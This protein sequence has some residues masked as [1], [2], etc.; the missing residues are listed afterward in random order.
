[1]RIEHKATSFK[2]TISLPGDKSIS[3]RSLLHS[4]M[5]ESD[6]LVGNLPFSKDVD[7]T[8][9]ALWDLGAP[10]VGNSQHEYWV[11]SLGWQERRS[12]NLVNCH[13]SATTMRLLMGILAGCES[14]SMLTGDESLLK[15][16]MERVAEPLRMMG[17]EISTNNGYPPVVIKGR[18][19]L[20]PIRYKLPI[21]SAQ[22][23]SSLIYAAMLANGDSVI[24]EPVLSRDH[25]EIALETLCP[26]NYRR[27]TSKGVI[28]HF[29]EGEMYFP[30]FKI[31]IPGDPSSAAFLAALALL[32]PDSEITF[33]GI[34]LNPRRIRYLEILKVMGGDIEITESG[35]ELGERVGDV[36]VRSSELKNIEIQTEDIPLI[37]DEIPIL[38]VIA[39]K[40]QGE[41]IIHGAEELRVKESDRI[42]SMVLNLRLLGCEV[43][44]Y[45]DGLRLKGKSKLSA[46]PINHK[47]DH[48]I[49]MSLIVLS[50]VHNLDLEF[51][52][53]SA[54]PISFPEFLD[55]INLLSK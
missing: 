48:R 55:F 15:R 3:H 1:M 8:A 17:A 4:F 21:P 38:T 35:K 49:L 16:P 12:K 36:T 51:D 37:I 54:L 19:P 27:K 46:A 41:F 42:A 10:V 14:E 23:K 52:D 9:E 50:M 47:G 7:S 40:S 28:R 30:F 5:S 43:E 25:T 31:N 53:L 44:E 6:S 18:T 2:G 45:Q 39:T 20:K 29:I 34:L 26:G 32:T 11:M 33:K 24:I 13:N 22:L